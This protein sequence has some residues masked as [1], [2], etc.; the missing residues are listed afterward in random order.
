MWLGHEF[1]GQKAF[2]KAL[3]RFVI[4]NN[5]NFKHLKCYSYTVTAKCMN[6]NCQWHIHASIVDSEPIF[7]I[8]TYNRTH[9]CLKAK[10]GMAHKSTTPELIAEHIIDKVEVNNEYKLKEIIANFQKEDG[11]KI[12]YDKA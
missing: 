5:F 4:Y 12:S 1:G 6:E 9:K 10:M 11:V 2:C 8:R 7:K 3:R